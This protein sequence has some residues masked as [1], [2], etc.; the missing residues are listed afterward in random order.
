MG[1]F[2]LIG[3]KVALKVGVT[4]LRVRLCVVENHAVMAAGEAGDGVNVGIGQLLYPGRGIKF[5]ADMRDLFAGVKVEV[6]LTVAEEV[7][8]RVVRSC[9]MG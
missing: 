9:G 6:D 1:G 4:P 2:D 8:H 3:Q 7:R 5:A